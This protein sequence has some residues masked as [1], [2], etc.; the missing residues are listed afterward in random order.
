MN[1]NNNNWLLVSEL[2][3]SLI[4]FNE[5]C[6]PPVAFW[7]LQSLSLEST[8]QIMNPHESSLQT[9]FNFVENGASQRMRQSRSALTNRGSVF[10]FFTISIWGSL[11]KIPYYLSDNFL[12]VYFLFWFIND[13]TWFIIISYKLLFWIPIPVTISNPFWNTARQDFYFRLSN[14]G[15]YLD[16]L[17]KFLRF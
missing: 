9:S 15:F 12:F 4:V 11:S 16:R 13:Q 1:K 5:G 10:S 14:K 7:P 3:R 6:L 8:T 17:A 2:S